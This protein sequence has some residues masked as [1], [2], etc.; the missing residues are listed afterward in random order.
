MEENVNRNSTASSLKITDLRIATLVGVPF[1]STIIRIDTNQ[2]ISGYGEVRDGASKTY[3][4]LLKSR[5]I[6]EN[7]RDVDRL[8]RKIRQ[9]GHHARQA[10]GVCGV[11]MALMDLAGKVYGAPAHALAGGSFRDH[12]LCYTDTPAAEDPREMGRRL[13]ER[14]ARGFKFLKMDVGIGLLKDIPGAVIAPP[15]ALDTRTTMHPFTGI[16][17]TQKGVE[18]L[19]EYVAG[20]R[21]TVGYDIPLAAD[22]FGHIALDSCIRIGRALE[23]YTLAWLEDMIPWQLTDQWRQLTE[24]IATPT[25]T[26]E[27]IYLHDN[28]RPLLEAG[29][30]RVIHPDPATSGGILETKRIGDLAQEH[31]VAMALHMAAS[32]IATLAAVHIAAATEN[33]LALEHHAADVPW[34]GDLV[35]GL[36]RPLIEDGMIAVPEAPGLGFEDINE[37]VF[38]EHLD[39]QSPVYFESTHGWDGESSQDRLWS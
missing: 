32:P 20:V 14:R 31:G 27:D 9:F 36:P 15:G 39:P 8:F 13:V 24:A 10:G 5:L 19:V 21:S 11:E 30:V 1:R 34:W 26:G 4:L 33:F 23:P 7:P 37:E 28:F 29:A 25:C 3:A 22:H 35:T 17:V 18:C 2:G 12:I 16:Q 38:R 6:G